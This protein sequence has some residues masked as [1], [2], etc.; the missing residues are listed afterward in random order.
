MS[1]HSQSRSAQPK[2]RVRRLVVLAAVLAAALMLGLASMSASASDSPPGHGPAPV[3]AYSPLPHTH[4]HNDYQHDHPLFDALSNQFDSVEADI[5]LADDGALVTD[6]LL[7]GHDKSA[8]QHGRR[9]Q[10]LY[11]DPLLH[12]VNTN[13]NRHVYAGSTAQVTLLIDVKSDAAS[14]Y[15]VLDALLRSPSYDPLL[16]SWTKTGPNTWVETP[17]PVRVI[18]SGNRD[19]A[20]LLG[21][22]TRRAAY[23]G[24]LADL[25]DGL[26]ASFMPWI[27]NSW[28]S[29]FQWHGSGP[30]P[31][32]ERA[33]L[34]HI[35]AN[36]HATPGQQLRFYATPDRS[37]Q[38]YLSVWQ[39]ERLAG[40]DW[41]NTDELAA[42]R[43]FLTNNP[44]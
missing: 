8:L 13:A 39:E 9:L 17:G 38:Q 5:W 15:R 4:A 25:G 16:T 7:V 41:L 21:Q 42:L 14:T 10:D 44:Y 37:A 43:T 33:L 3:P 40:V 12:L 28:S 31:D 19:K 36:V 1:S 34:R 23:D 27:S 20:Y 11:L 22:P 29:V 32:D 26:P 24:R 2:G 30:M 18:I 35:V 6:P